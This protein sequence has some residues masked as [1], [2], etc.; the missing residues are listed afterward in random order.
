MNGDWERLLRFVRDSWNVPS[1]DLAG[2]PR[3]VVGGYGRRSWLIELVSS[4][5]SR[6]RCVQL[7]CSDP[8]KASLALEVERLRWL[9]ARGFPISPPL[10]WVADPS[11]LGEP[12]ALIEWV[13]GQTLADRIWTE[14]WRG[15][16]ADGQTIGLLLARLHALPCH[17]FPSEAQSRSGAPPLDRVGGLLGAT[18]SDALNGW[19]DGH[20]AVSPASVVC[21]LDLHPLNV[22]L[23]KDGPVVI[24]WEM[25]RVDHPLMDVAMSQVHTE[26]ALGI[27]EYPRVADRLAYGRDVL[28]AYRSRRPVDEAE[29]AYFRVLAACRRLDDVAGALQRPGLHAG[30]RAELEAEGASAISLLD[31]EIDQRDRS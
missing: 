7:R 20:R 16:G 27:G 26:V 24:D 29:L 8:G 13:P 6:S 23:S 15:N 9:A 2:E 17:G 12:F 14:G 4:E 22:V 19:L 10:G 11:L 5:W 18:R 28:D 3:P 25:A 21:H 31:R 1:I 30:D